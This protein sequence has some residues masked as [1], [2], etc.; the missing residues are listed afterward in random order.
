MGA[1]IIR[2]LLFW[3][4]GSAP[5]VWNS[6]IALPVR[7]YIITMRNPTYGRTILNVDGSS[8]GSSLSS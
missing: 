5:N 3:V 1:L 7:H 2:A 6:H 4:C 8:N